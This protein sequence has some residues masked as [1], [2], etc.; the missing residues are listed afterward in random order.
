MANPGEYLTANI[1]TPSSAELEFTAQKI[2]VTQDGTDPTLPTT[3]LATDGT[4]T[5]SL[6]FSSGTGITSVI[7][8]NNGFELK[9]NNQIAKTGFTIFPKGTDNNNPGYFSAVVTN[10][11]KDE[12]ITGTCNFKS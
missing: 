6:K 11:G 3:V 7:Y 8:I 10:S 1:H 2:E 5:I 12:L 9:Y 4:N